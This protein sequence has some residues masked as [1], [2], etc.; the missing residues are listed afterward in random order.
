ME[1]NNGT[2]SEKDRI[3]IESTMTLVAINRKIREL[4]K[5]DVT[6]ENEKTIDDIIEEQ[7]RSGLDIE[8]F[9]NREAE[10]VNKLLEDEPDENF[11]GILDIVL[12]S[13]NISKI[14]P[15]L[16]DIGGDVRAKVAMLLTWGRKN[17][18][19]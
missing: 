2:L 10:K 7:K 12:S 5:E 8:G 11:N 13:T 16:G 4:N 9:M 19:V 14:S 17:K 15:I 6:G 3:L 18:T 1:H